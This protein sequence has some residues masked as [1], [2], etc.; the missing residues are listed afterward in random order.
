MLAQIS[1]ASISLS[2]TM[3]LWG[4]RPRD[5]SQASGTEA[6]AQITITGQTAR[7]RYQLCAKW[8]R[9]QRTRLWSIPDTV[10]PRVI[11]NEAMRPPEITQLT[12]PRARCRNEIASIRL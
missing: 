7:G 5:A 10:L 6:A 9:G 3:K 2:T 8:L 1:K 11:T 12:T 4:K